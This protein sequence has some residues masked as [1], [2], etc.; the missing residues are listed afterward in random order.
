MNN[1]DNSFT[2]NINSNY[3]SNEINFYSDSNDLESQNIKFNYIQD[4]LKLSNKNQVPLKGI[5]KHQDE[6][7]KLEEIIRFRIVKFCLIVLCIILSSPL[8]FADLYFGFID[9]ICINNEANNLSLSMKLYLLVSGFITFGITMFIM[10]CIY[11]LEYNKDFNIKNYFILHIILK[12]IGLFNMI[13]NIIG[14]VI[15]WEKIY[16]DDICDKNI[17]TYIFISLIIKYALNLL[18][19]FKK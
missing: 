5:L 12:I 13:W 8:A 4:S 6:N 16:K 17:K 3:N 2:N 18:Y 15:Y 1:I 9:N 19:I 14:G 11:S 10:Y 7:N